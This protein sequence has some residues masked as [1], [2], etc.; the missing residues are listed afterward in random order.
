M[1]LD[2]VYPLDALAAGGVIDFDAPAFILDKPARYVGS[3][4]Y[5]DILNIDNTALL[6]EG[7]KMKQQPKS[8]EFGDDSKNIVKNPSWKKWVTGGIIGTLAASLILGILTKK[9]KIKLPDMTKVKNT[10]KN[11]GSNAWNYIK[12]PFTF[13]AGKFKKP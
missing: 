5:E 3:P 6:P 9:G 2:W 8:D 13:I 1:S 11:L 10:I 4:R 12:M 7:T